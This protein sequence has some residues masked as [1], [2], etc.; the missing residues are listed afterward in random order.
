MKV[1]LVGLGILVHGSAGLAYY[2]N[3]RG[4]NIPALQSLRP[5]AV[6]ELGISPKGEYFKHVSVRGRINLDVRQNDHGKYGS[7]GI[8]LGF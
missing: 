2:E 5:Q 4:N 6:G 7:V 1:L 8:Y 3:W